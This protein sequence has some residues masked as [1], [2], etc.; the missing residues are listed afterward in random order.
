MKLR[1]TLTLLLLLSGVPLW[2]QR[3]GPFTLS[4]NN[5]CTPAIAIAPG[6]NASVAID[7]SGTFTGTLQPEILMTGQTARNTIVIPT[8]SQTTQ[9]TITAVGGYTAIQVTGYDSFQLCVSGGALSGPATIYLTPSTAPVA[10]LGG[11]GGGGGDTI[12]SPNS[13]LNVGGSSSATTLDVAGA[14][15][16]ILAGA[17]PALT[18]TP[19]LGLSGTTGSLALVNTNGSTT[20]TIT[21]NTT[22][23]TLGTITSGTWNG[24]LIGSTYGGTGVN[25]GSA[26]ITLGTSSLNFATLGTGIIKN[27]TTTGALTNAAAADIYGLFTSCTG[28]SGLFLKDGGTCA[29]AGGTTLAESSLTGSAAATTITET[30]ASNSITRAGVATANLTAPQVIQ[31]TNS[32]NNNTSITLGLSAPGTST[33]QTVLNV[34]GAS[35]GGDLA[36]FGTGGTWTAGVLSG[37]T[38]VSSVLINGAF[39]SKGTTA[40][41]IDL[42][43]GS[44]SA[45]VAPCNAA[46]SICFQAPTSV[47]SQLRV[48]AGAPATGFSLYT[49]SSGTMTETISATSGTLSSGVGVLGTL[50][51]NAVLASTVANAAGHFTNLQVVT[52]LGGTCSTV[53][54]FNVFDGT[55]NTGSTVTATSSTQTKGTGTSTAQTLTFAAGD[56]IG[57]YISTA[58]ATCTLDQFI[59]SAQYSIP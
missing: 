4:A 54:I 48:L 37:Q 55:T 15:G 17:T 23:L 59:V 36:D 5:S 2:A 26:T 45:S 10:Q 57:I 29:A 16:E 6:N 8:T 19:T 47:T 33:G 22:G 12:T 18:A 25:N 43:Q 50:A 44:T 49:N 53:P 40:G 56:V 51:V 28:S 39:Q 24:T 42:A 52:S 1:L 7:V 41:F 20:N 13:T 30:G 14:A 35:T 31:N 27:T 9:S 46:T 32:S 34:N 3:N 58:G 21:E 38:I 11:G